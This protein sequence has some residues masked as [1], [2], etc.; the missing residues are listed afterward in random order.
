MTELESQ[1]APPA[2]IEEP[3]HSITLWDLTDLAVREI[4][5]RFPEIDPDAMRLLMSLNCSA[6]LI[7]YD[8]QTVIREQQGSIP[9]LSPLFVLSLFD[10]IE[11]RD[12][13]RLCNRSRAGIS[14]IVDEMVEGGLVTRR[15]SPDDRRVMIVK[16]TD[17]GRQVFRDSFA[18]YNKRE[19][20]WSAALTPDERDQFVHLLGKMM[21]FRIN[22][23][24]IRLR[25]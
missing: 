9:I 17:A 3:S 24:D 16:I 7:F 4:P 8:I 6:D 12:L 25:K 18:L 1:I 22:D 11:M 23:P 2:G 21:N 10:E 14:M 5:K 13:T 20:Y 19:Q 15:T